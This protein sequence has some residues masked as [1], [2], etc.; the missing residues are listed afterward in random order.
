[1]RIWSIHPEYLDTKG[2]VA[3]WRE[4]LLAKKVL[5]R[6]TRGYTNH[7]QLYR[8][9]R[10]ED[11]LALITRYLYSLYSEAERRNFNFDLS[12]IE[13]PGN[14]YRKISVNSE[15]ITYEFC[16]LLFKLQ[17]RD[18]V[19][20]NEIRETRSIEVN[21]VFTETAGGIEDWERIIPEITLMMRENKG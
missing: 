3:A 21:P 10:S 15:Q 13:P 12:K 4:G 16:L 5:E 11:C 2:L 14:P 6:K 7:P 20:Y 8:F 19:K 1:M 18:V 17:K 9:H